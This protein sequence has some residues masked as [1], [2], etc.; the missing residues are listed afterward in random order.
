MIAAGPELLQTRPHCTD[1]IAAKMKRRASVGYG[2]PGGSLVADV[3]PGLQAAWGWVVASTAPPV[4]SSTVPPQIPT[5][6]MRGGS[7][8]D[9][10]LDPKVIGPC[11]WLYVLRLQAPKPV[12]AVIGDTPSRVAAARQCGWPT[13]DTF[14]N[15]VEEYVAVDCAHLQAEGRAA[16]RTC[17]Y[18]G[19]IFWQYSPCHHCNIFFGEDL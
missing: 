12:C 2:L 8:R 5:T 16:M 6:E 14:V 9:V 1:D 13:P 3:E 4:A 15:V 7:I 19:C 11:L 17:G 10:A 18:A